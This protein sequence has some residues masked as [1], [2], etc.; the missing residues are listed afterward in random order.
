[1]DGAVAFK[2][3][4]AWDHAEVAGAGRLHSFPA[5][6]LHHHWGP[7]VLSLGPHHTNHQEAERLAP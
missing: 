2:C 4:I 6:H 7:S 5:G 1:M 3:Q